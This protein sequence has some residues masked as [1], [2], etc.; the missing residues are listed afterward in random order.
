MIQATLRE[1]IKA[2]V[3]R[4]AAGQA[5]NLSDSRPGVLFPIRQHDPTVLQPYENEHGKIKNA[6]QRS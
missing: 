5:V 4:A 6:K 3:K 1:V 2:S